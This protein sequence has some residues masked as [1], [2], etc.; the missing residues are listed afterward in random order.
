M[1]ICRITVLHGAIAGMALCMVLFITGSRRPSPTA[2]Q[3]VRLAAGWH[4]RALSD[5]L[6]MAELPEQRRVWLYSLI[7]TDFPGGAH[8]CPFAVAELQGMSPVLSVPASC[9]PCSRAAVRLLMH[10]DL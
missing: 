4:G 5:N 7:G 3:E 9:C 6:T 2:A 1:R 8:C 10:L